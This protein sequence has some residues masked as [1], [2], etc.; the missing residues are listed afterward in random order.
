[1]NIGGTVEFAGI[2]FTMTDARHSSSIDEA[3]RKVDGG[4]AAGF[5]IKAGD[6]SFY[7]AG[8]TGLFVDME[9][10]SKLYSPYVA[11]LPIGGR[12]TMGPDDAVLAVGMLRPKIVIP[13]HYNTFDVIS[14]DPDI[15]ASNVKAVSNA[16]VKIMKIGES[17]FL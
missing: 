11:L 8:D 3:G 6:M 17:I 4:K 15:F 5:V 2:S 14:Q 10:I 1:M 13:M 7:H 12:Y 9:L 16:D